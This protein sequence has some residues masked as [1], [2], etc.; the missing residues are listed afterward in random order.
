MWNIFRYIADFTHLFSVLILLYKMITKKTSVGVSLKTHIIYLSVYLFRY[1]NSAFFSPPLYNILFKIFYIAA[2]VVIIV[3]IKFVYKRTYEVRQDNFRIIF[4]YLLC[5]P[6]AYFTAPRST[7]YILCHS[8]SLWL[9][10]FAIIPQIL[11]FS[12]SR[13]IDVM[14]KDYVFLLSIYRLFYLLNWIYKAV[15]ET[16]STPMNVWITGILQTVIYADF[17]WVYIKA[18]VTGSEFELPY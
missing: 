4:I 14:G 11:L 12:R 7:W 16:G 1:I 9:E 6:L 15:T 13:K 8:Y 3:L 10:P 2:E 5:L 17:I 18:K